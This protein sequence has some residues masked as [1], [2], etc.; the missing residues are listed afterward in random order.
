MSYVDILYIL[1]YVGILDILNYKTFYII[2]KIIKTFTD[3]ISVIRYCFSVVVKRSQFRHIDCLRPI[4]C[5]G[6]IAS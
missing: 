6:I 1:T 3:L 2:R 5:K 4:L